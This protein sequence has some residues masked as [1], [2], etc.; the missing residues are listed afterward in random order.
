M[1]IE[2]PDL[3]MLALDIVQD[4]VTKESVLSEQEFYSFERDLLEEYISTLEES[5]EGD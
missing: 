3:Y 2:R 5:I 4:N 1:N